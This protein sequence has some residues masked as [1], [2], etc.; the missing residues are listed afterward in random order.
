MDK[1]LVSYTNGIDEEV[2]GY[3]D[4]TKI[5]EECS[6]RSRKRNTRT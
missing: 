6:K 2:K 3:V 4:L 1:V 5:I